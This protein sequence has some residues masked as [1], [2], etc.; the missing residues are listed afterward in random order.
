MPTSIL[1]VK[2]FSI[3]VPCFHG[4]REQRAPFGESAR[5]SGGKAGILESSLPW[6]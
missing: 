4:R 2:L 6:I 1:K 3:L 5:D